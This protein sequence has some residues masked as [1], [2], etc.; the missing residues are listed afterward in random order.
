MF[1]A[2]APAGNCASQFP[3]LGSPL[4]LHIPAAELQQSKG[5]FGT[6]F[7]WSGRPETLLLFARSRSPAPIAALA[8]KLAVRPQLRFVNLRL[9][10][11]GGGGI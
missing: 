8:R 9:T 4:V 2:L 10:I 11:S 6:V 3:N 7:T 5:L 1:L